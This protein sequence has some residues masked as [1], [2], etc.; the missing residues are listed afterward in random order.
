MTSLPFFIRPMLAVSAPPFDAADYLFEPKWDGFRCLA[1]IED[2]TRLQSRNLR[3][4]N[5]DYPELLDLHR[6]VKAAPCVL[7]GEIVAFVNG[8][9][10]FRALQ[11]RRRSRRSPLFLGH[12]VV[13]MA[14][15]LLYA[16]GQDLT[17]L[18]L[19]RRHEMLAEAL[20]ESDRLLLTQS[21]KERGRDYFAAAVS[22]GLEGVVGKKIDSP[23]LAGRRSRYWVKC[24]KRRVTSFVICGYTE[25]ERDGRGLGALALGAYENGVLR[26]FGLVGT[27]FA[28]SDLAFFADILPGLKSGRC[29]F[30]P[31][32]KP[33][34][35][36]HWVRPLLVCD[37][38]YLEL[39]QEGV[40][41][42]PVF[43]R[44]RPDLAP[45]DC[46]FPPAEE[47]EDA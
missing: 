6:L 14:F 44:L 23:Y 35:G 9:P 43:L 46:V 32:P 42:Q 11:Y 2:G 8:K 39:T 19:Y 25:N 27:G 21:V 26:F 38:E 4:M 13:Y 18:P 22:L 31:E 3:I 12:P 17:R 30:I 29:P 47:G 40:L 1:F 5:E 20:M 41:R 24:K 15:D 33:V 37:V 28:R 45:S 16:R 7:D 36:L 10:S 34:K